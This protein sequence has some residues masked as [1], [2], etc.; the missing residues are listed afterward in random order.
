MFWENVKT[1]R[2]IISE[3][4]SPKIPL[5]LPLLGHAEKSYTM[6]V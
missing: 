2:G 6:T 1:A 5:T 4:R 3:L